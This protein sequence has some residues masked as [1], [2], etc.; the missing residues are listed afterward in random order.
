MPLIRQLSPHLAD[1]IAAG[2]VVERPASVVK[3]LLE[4]AIDAGA[5]AVSVELRRGGMS[6]IRIS[7]NGCG[8]APE[9]LKTAFLRHA[10]SKL[11]TEEDLACI[12]TLG[13]RGE[14]LA[15]IAAVSRIE[16]LSRR[17]GA[18]QGAKL[19]LEGGV[20]GEVEAC[21]C[22]EGTV[23]SVRDLFYNTP[24]R[25]KFMKKDSAETS[26]AA[27]V[28]QHEALS[29]ARISFKLIRDGAE[30]LCTPGD[31][32]LL[33]AI[34]SALGREFALSL[35][36]VE[37]RDGAV[38]VE[39]FVSRSLQCRGSRSM[40]HFYVNGRY[41]KS[42]LLT[43][44]LEEAYRNQMMKGKFPGC[45][46]HLSLPLDAVDVNV[47]PAKTVVKFLNERV[48]FD[49]VHYAVKRALE[50]GGEGSA[51]MRASSSAPG[52]AQRT[53]PFYQTMTAQEFRTRE[54]GAGKPL[55]SFTQRKATAYAAELPGTAAVA[56]SV[57]PAE[58]PRTAAP[59]PIPRSAAPLT[60]TAVPAAPGQKAAE[61]PPAQ[62]APAPVQ[63]ESIPA[64]AAPQRESI[65][66]PT[67]SE[68]AA[69]AGMPP[70]EIPA[71]E[72]AEEACGETAQTR[73]EAECEAPWRIA[74]EVLRT[75]I[76]CEDGAGNVYLIDKHAAHERI[77]FDRMKRSTAP[78]MGQ[79]LLV[80]EAVTLA[81]DEYAVLL[82]HLEALNRFG[83]EAEDFGD[84]TILCRTCPDRIDPAA[85]A[86]ALEEIAAEILRTGR[87]DPESARDAML[88]TMACKAA[89]KAGMVSDERELR[90]L[91]DKVQS[92]EIQF[93][94]HGR[95]V[96]V[97]LS[98]YELEKMFKRA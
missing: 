23:I 22:P 6:L 65:P 47:H 51:E 69:P 62:A 24:A 44:A 25:M 12:G 92:G 67:P 80:P 89:I 82:E 35:L 85:I 27:A 75:Y 50:A 74:G 42:A 72:S 96:K 13:F 34:Y 73:L 14:A 98:K 57:R 20:A 64:P 86:P 39:G 66:A 59:V 4:N 70:S 31:G 5:S 10:T 7:D 45:V 15:A 53:T 1:M 91:V 94:P 37:G 30:Q 8:I 77:N 52:Q 18:P 76:I 40:Q 71:Q 26:A 83:F 2:E 48:A 43:A 32:K 60:P 79:Q 19:T 49:A 87:A 78:I 88:H 84:N 55:T 95:P 33:N 97:K 41:V 61:E 16:I 54:A 28:V 11:Q 58:T 46:L 9:E 56:D 3:E 90:I 21:G 93:C 36:P 29:H 63:R 68:T 38:L 17:R 81:A